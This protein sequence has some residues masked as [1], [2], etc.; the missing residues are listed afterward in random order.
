MTLKFR[1]PDTAALAPGDKNDSFEANA[2]K[3]AG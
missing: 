3:P 2:A 1:K